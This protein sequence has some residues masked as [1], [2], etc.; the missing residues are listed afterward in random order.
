VY[1][2]A[3]T[4]AWAKRNADAGVTTSH[5][6]SGNASTIAATDA[7]G[8]AGARWRVSGESGSSVRWDGRGRIVIVGGATL[9]G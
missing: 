9:A 6:T 2:R 8:D 7:G 1:T 5:V 4:D 3:A